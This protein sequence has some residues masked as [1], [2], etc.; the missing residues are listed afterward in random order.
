M[1]MK[2]VVAA[3]IIFG[4]LPQAIFGSA[5]V[6]MSLNKKNVVGCAERMAKAIDAVAPY[7]ME[8]AKG[9]KKFYKD[10]IVKTIVNPIR[11]GG[12]EYDSSIFQMA[13]MISTKTMPKD[14]EFQSAMLFLYMNLAQSAH[15]LKAYGFISQNTFDALLEI[16]KQK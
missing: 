8:M 6:T 16:E 14:K 7:E 9:D 4:M 2:I 10:I 15:I 5:G 12:F 3:V 1:K 11:D 13:K